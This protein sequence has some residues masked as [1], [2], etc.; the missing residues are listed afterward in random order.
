MILVL[1][2]TLLVLWNIISTIFFL[3]TTSNYIAFFIY[4]VRFLSVFVVLL[5]Q[6]KPFF[7]VLM[8]L[9]K[10]VLKT[11]AFKGK[12]ILSFKHHVGLTYFCN[13]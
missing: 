2:S 9:Y 10:I 13:V 3:F 7:R 12:L 11:L 8:W 4:L 6:L 1:S 5:H